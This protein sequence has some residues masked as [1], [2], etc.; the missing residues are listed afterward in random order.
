LDSFA[1]KRHL[2][3]D[4]RIVDTFFSATFLSAIQLK[5]VASIRIND[6][7]SG[8]YAMCGS[9]QFKLKIIC[10]IQKATCAIV[11]ND[12]PRNKGLF[13]SSAKLFNWRL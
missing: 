3:R 8:E 9:T 10:W 2:F 6:P 7:K 1:K 12:F 4:N 13:C 11:Q 5:N